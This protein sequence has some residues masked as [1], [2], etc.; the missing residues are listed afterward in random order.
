MFVLLSV[1]TNTIVPVPSETVLFYFLAK[2]PGSTLH[3]VLIGSFCAAAGGLIDLV[4]ADRIR[5]RLFRQETI[6]SFR[7]YSIVFLFALLPLPFSL[8]R[9]SLLKYR[10]SPSMYFLTI[11]GGRFIRY[12][13]L[14]A[15]TSGWGFSIGIM[16][17]ALVLLFAWIF[18]RNG[19]ANRRILSDVLP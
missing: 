5:R 11:L 17:G 19:F 6:I 3:L 15:T 8:I 18:Q 13:L 9:A 16:L 7:F 14:A 4:L 1:G 10:P 2:Y 12:L